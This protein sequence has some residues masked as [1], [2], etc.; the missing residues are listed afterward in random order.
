MNACP[1]SC[2]YTC[3]HACL[4]TCL[5]TAPN[6]ATTGGKIICLLIFLTVCA[7]GYAAYG[8][9]RLLALRVHTHLCLRACTHAHTTAHT[10]RRRVPHGVTRRGTVVALLCR[11]VVK[12]CPWVRREAALPSPKPCLATTA[13]FFNTRHVSA[14]VYTQVLQ[15]RRAFER[16]LT[17]GH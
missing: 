14:H 11:V 10:H 5:Y 16:R 1:Y 17:S 15:G 12:A 3:L 2:P 4:Q 7:A 6:L 9:T 13:H 8:Y